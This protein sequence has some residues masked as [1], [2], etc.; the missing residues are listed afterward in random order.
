MVYSSVF[1]S[2]W[3]PLSSYIHRVN[4]AYSASQLLGL[5]IIKIMHLLH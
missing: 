5:D 2:F 3:N 1:R 4:L